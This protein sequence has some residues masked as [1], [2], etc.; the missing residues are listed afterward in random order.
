MDAGKLKDRIELYTVTTTAD[1]QGGSTAT[2]TLESTRYAEVKQLSM[3]ESLRS[4]MVVGE[5]NYRITLRRPT[6][7]EFN[8]SATQ[9]R[10]NGKK[11]NVTG[12]ITDVFWYTINATEKV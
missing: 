10:W 8:R 5:S 3:N 6:G 11:M 1:G 9:I 4:G 12:V 7:V 2:Y